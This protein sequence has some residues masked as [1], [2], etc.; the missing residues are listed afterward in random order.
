MQPSHRPARAWAETVLA[1]FTG[2]LFLLT[3]VRRDWLEAFG[4][5]PDGHDGAAE[6]LVVAGLFAL[7]V[8]FT[9]SA[10]L[11]WRRQALAR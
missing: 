1:G 8:A 6:W 5:D 4:I 9:V 11:E 3:L 10:R 2:V 7:F